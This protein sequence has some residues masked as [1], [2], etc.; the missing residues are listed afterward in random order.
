MECLKCSRVFSAST[1]SSISLAFS[2]H[3]WEGIQISNPNTS[4]FFTVAL[5]PNRI[6][7]VLFF[8]STSCSSPFPQSISPSLCLEQ[9][10]KSKSFPFAL[11]FLSFRFPRFSNT[12][13]CRIR[14]FVTEFERRVSATFQFRSVSWRYELTLF[15]VFVLGYFWIYRF[16]MMGCLCEM[17]G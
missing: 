4:I 8:Q 6:Y 2:L 1:F 12:S 9:I 13:I 3:S 5:A 15:H 14:A 10:L 16:E 11:V 17:W 7:K